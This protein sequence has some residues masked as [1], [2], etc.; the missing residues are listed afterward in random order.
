QSNSERR[1]SA[2]SS[3]RRTGPTWNHPSGRRPAHPNQLAAGPPS[4]SLDR[5]C[6]ACRCGL[7]GWIGRDLHVKNLPAGVLGHEKHVQRSKRD[8][9]DAKESHAQ[10]SDPFCLRNDRRVEDGP[11]R[12]ISCIYLATVL[13]ETL[14]PSL[15]SS[16]WILRWPQS[17]LSAAMHRIRVL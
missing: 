16:A 6:S 14:N 15:E 11:R 5:P 3:A 8:R 12:L 2:C 13:A 4:F 10:I 17:R 9:L 1:S 7:G